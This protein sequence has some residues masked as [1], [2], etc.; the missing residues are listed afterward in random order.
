MKSIKTFGELTKHL[1]ETGMRKKVAVVWAADESTQHAVEQALADGFIEATFVGCAQE[2]QSQDFYKTH[3]EHI[4]LVEATTPDEAATAAVALV[5]EGNADVL[6]KGLI[7][8]DNLLHAVLNKQ[9]GILPKGNIL[10]HVTVADIPAY[11]KLLLFTDAAVIPYP[12]HE[13]RIKQVEYAASV[14]H[15][16]G[17]DCPRISLIH[18]SEKVNEKYFPFTVGYKEIAQMAIDGKLGQCIVDGPLDV[19]TSCCAE[20][21]STKGICSPIEGKADALIFPDIEAGNAFYKTITLFA[22]AQTAGLL[23]GTMAPVVVSSRSDS[24]QSKYNSLAV[25][26]MIA[27]KA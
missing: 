1:A 14:C 11:D 10:T 24:T 7:N 22:G 5:R 18:C 2:I 4:T 21:M 23:Q 19:K 12:T 20:S 6:M 13:Q 16:M 27:P 8:T 17:V 26:A 9:T 25:A 15:S 3:K